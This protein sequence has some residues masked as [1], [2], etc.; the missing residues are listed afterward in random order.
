[1]LKIL[2]RK[3]IAKLREKIENKVGVD[4]Y[5][6]ALV[7][8]EKTLINSRSTQSYFREY[9]N[10]GGRSRLWSDIEKIRKL[11]RS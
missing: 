1:M 7:D 11:Q 5:N 2:T 6:Q 10:S 4:I 9:I 3:G 8:A